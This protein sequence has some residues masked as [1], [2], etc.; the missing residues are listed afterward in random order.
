MELDLKKL[1]ANNKK[2][3]DVDFEALDSVIEN[4]SYPSEVRTKNDAFLTLPSRKVPKKTIQVDPKKTRLWQGNPRNFALAISIDDLLPKIKKSKGNLQPVLARKLAVADENGCTIE[5]IFGCRRR[6]SCIEANTLL[7]A[8]LVDIDDDEAKYLAIEENE[9]RLDNDFIADCRYLHSEYER[10][11]V[12]NNGKL[13]VE[14]FAKMNDQARQ[15]M[16]EKL[17]IAALPDTL[18]NSVVDAYSW[19]LRNSTKVKSAFK[20]FETKEDK[21]ILLTELKSKRFQKVDSL[22]KFFDELNGVEKVV[23]ESEYKLGDS[24]VSVKKDSKNIKINIPLKNSS[25]VFH[26]IEAILSKY[27]IDS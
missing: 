23:D 7:T 24:V 20:K 21:E 6:L 4:A 18:F 16:S 5:V 2:S 17:H 13:S 3:I 11:K 15:T 12:V 19:T 22:L 14:D 9:G 1:D 10:L 8:D 27:S 26:E 25:K